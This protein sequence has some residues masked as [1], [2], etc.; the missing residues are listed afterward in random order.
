[1][2]GVF[3]VK[4]IKT[5]VTISDEVFE[6]ARAFSNNFSSFVN[7]ALKFYIKMKNIEKGKASFG[8]WTDRDKPSTDLVDEV[9]NDRGRDYSNRHN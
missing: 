6:E 3:Q 7:E 8:K 9:R 4:S 2:G 5:S 1:L